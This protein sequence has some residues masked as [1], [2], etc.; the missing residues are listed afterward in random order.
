MLTIVATVSGVTLVAAPA[1]QLVLTYTVADSDLFITS[2]RAVVDWGD[3]SA[4]EVTSGA[5]PLGPTTLRHGYQA[6]QY[7][8]TVRAQNYRSPTPDTALYQQRIT[9]AV[10][11]AGAPDAPPVIFGPILPRTQGFPSVSTWSFNVG[12]DA[13][14][15]ESSLRMLL[16]TRRG[17]RLYDP[18]YGTNLSALVFALNTDDLGQAIRTEIAQAVAAYEPR[19]ELL[20]AATVKGADKKSVIVTAEFRSLLSGQPIVLDFSVAA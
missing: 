4:Q 7:V 15:L 13:V 17:E 12:R 20:N 10:A 18:N 1:A 14:N 2:A 3:G 19:V 16:L 5:P 9:V 8:V 11:N 6:G